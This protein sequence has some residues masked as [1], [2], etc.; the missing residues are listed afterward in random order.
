MNHLETLTGT[1]SKQQICKMMSTKNADKYFYYDKKEK[2]IIPK[3]N[4]YLNGQSLLQTHQLSSEDNSK[5][6]AI[7]IYANYNEKTKHY[8]PK[9][10][11]E[12]FYW[13]NDND[14]RFDGCAKENCIVDFTKKIVGNN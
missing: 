10:A 14:C 13:K 5:S 6:I 7:S 4:Y 11:F 3:Y 1:V 12:L 9:I 8:E 2:E